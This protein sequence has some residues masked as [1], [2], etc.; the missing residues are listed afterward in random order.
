MVPQSKIDDEITQGIGQQVEDMVTVEIHIPWAP[1]KLH[2][3]YYL[4]GRFPVRKGTFGQ[5]LPLN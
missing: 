4:E 3:V 1:T 5:N 2:A